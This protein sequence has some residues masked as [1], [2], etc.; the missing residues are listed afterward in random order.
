M[1]LGIFGRLILADTDDARYFCRLVRM[2]TGHA[3]YGGTGY[4]VLDTVGPAATPLGSAALPELSASS[5]PTVTGLFPG[6]AT[7]IIR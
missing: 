6:D 1:I 3:Q 4:T 2:D 5:S 7:G